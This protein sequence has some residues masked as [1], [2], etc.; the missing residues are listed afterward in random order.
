MRGSKITIFGMI[1]CFNRRENCERFCFYFDLSAFEQ[2]LHFRA[3][4]NFFGNKVIPLPESESVRT[5]MSRVSD[6]E[7]N[8]NFHE[9]PF[10]ISCVKIRMTKTGVQVTMNDIVMRIRSFLNLR[11]D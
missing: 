2:H 3:L 4:C 5:P 11:R 1:N 6:I 8:F 9:F 10:P 7:N